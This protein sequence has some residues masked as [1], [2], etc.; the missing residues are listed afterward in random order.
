MIRAHGKSGLYQVQ[1]L[2]AFVQAEARMLVREQAGLSNYQRVGG[3]DPL[4]VSPSG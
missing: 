4:S 3:G 1:F 2:R